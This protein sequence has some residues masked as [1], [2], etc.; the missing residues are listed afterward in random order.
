STAHGNRC[1]IADDSPLSHGGRM[2][3]RIFLSFRQ[4]PESRKDQ[5][6]WTP[7][8]AGVTAFSH[9]LNLRVT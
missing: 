4:K 1:T 6:F 5:Q 9:T 3:E 8:S 7:A 2:E